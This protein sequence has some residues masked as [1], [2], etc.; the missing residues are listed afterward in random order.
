MKRHPTYKTPEESIDIIRDFKEWDEWKK[1]VSSLIDFYE[2]GDNIFVHGWIPL[3]I[4]D[5]GRDLIVHSNWRDGD[6]KNARWLCGMRQW[7]ANC[8]L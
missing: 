3:T 4:D 6:W 5:S 2:E 7:E 1:Y 8:Y